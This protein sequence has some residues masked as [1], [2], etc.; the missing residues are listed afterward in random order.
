VGREWYPLASQYLVVE[1]FP[2]V[3]HPGQAVTVSD[4]LAPPLSHLAPLRVGQPHQPQH[5]DGQRV[6]IAG[7]YQE[8]ALLVVH[9]LA[10]APDCRRDDR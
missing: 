4:M 6:G 10:T 3:G 1:G 7:G 9:D 5:R 8:S 2:P